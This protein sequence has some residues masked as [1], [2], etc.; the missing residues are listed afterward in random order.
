MSNFTVSLFGKF[1]IVR[2]GQGMQAI[3]SRKVQELLSY[4]LLYRDHPQSRESLS[5]ILWRD[6]LPAKSKKCLRQT[7][8][9]L[10]SFLRQPADSNGP[11]LLVDH[12]WIQINPS[13]DFRI[14]TVRFEQIYNSVIGKR[15]QELTRGDYKL[16]QKAIQLY[17]GD[18]LE[19]WYPDWCL[20]ERERFAIIYLMLLDKLVQYCEI[21]QDYVSGLIYAA[22]IL[23]HDHAYERAH[24]QM[25]R[26]YFLMGDRTQA[27]RQYR[28]CIVALRNE[29][30]VD[31]SG[32]TVQLYET[33]RSDTFRPLMQ[34]EKKSFAEMMQPAQSLVE[35]LQRL[36]SFSN[37][38]SQIQT[39]VQKEILDIRHTLPMDQ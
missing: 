10:Q 33:I 18:L 20:M 34:T 9:L 39:K 5:E 31:P 11:D 12:E 27:L 19:G 8:W 6:Q 2:S 1:N 28:R 15:V 22:K 29:L 24:R 38:L 23:R 7:L 30:D 16:I 13:I 14:D 36:M 32:E 17:K 25:M 37:E 3:K 21:H 35:A 26:L 4:L